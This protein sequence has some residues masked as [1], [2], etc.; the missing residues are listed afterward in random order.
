MMIKNTK[1]HLETFA[2]AKKATAME[3][4]M[5]LLKWF[6]ISLWY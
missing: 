2:Y 6:V 3:L 4:R 1:F 5:P